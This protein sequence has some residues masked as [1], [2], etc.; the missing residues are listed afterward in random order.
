MGQP[1][2]RIL[3]Y[4]NGR[5]QK[6]LVSSRALIVA[7]VISAAVWM[8]GHA[9]SA[10]PTKPLAP[11]TASNPQPVSLNVTRGPLAP[12]QAVTP[13][14]AL[15]PAVQQTIN[16]RYAPDNPPPS[17]YVHAAGFP[18]F[19]ALAPSSG[20]TM[21]AA[22]AFENGVSSFAVTCVNQIMAQ[23]SNPFVQVDC[24]AAQ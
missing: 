18:S 16:N 17:D 13:P 23:L 3:E 4:T 12:P 8:H 14:V 11:F 9:A 5:M 1:E 15:P 7:A 24:S 20:G 19:D 10:M 21:S 2:I 6:N 22:P